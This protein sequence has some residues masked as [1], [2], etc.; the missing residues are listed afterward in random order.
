MGSTLS[1]SVVVSLRL[2]I[3]ILIL[4][5][6]DMDI[7]APVVHVLKK[8]KSVKTAQPIG[9]KAS[10]PNSGIIREMMAY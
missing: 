9:R 8:V 5:E 3:I 10:P 1:Q 7:S 2:L 4:F 6:N